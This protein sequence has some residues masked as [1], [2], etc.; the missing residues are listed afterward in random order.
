MS[1]HQVCSWEV[2]SGICHRVWVYNDGTWI[3]NFER[4]EFFPSKGMGSF[5]TT[6]R[7]SVPTNGSGIYH[8][9]LLLYVLGSP[10]TTCL[11]YILARYQEYIPLLQLTPSFLRASGSNHTGPELSGLATCEYWLYVSN[12]KLK[13]V[14]FP[15]AHILCEDQG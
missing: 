5:P 10:N 3:L 15:L 6:G 4:F 7:E 12:G 1:L 2:Y 14:T 13:V 11:F 9:Y 8:Y